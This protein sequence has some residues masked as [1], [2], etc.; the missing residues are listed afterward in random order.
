MTNNILAPIVSLLLL[1]FAGTA[2]GQIVKPEQR[3]V[4]VVK[5]KPAY[6]QK[7][8]LL[9]QLPVARAS[10]IGFTVK[11]AFPG[12]QPP[13]QRQVEGGAVDLSLVYFIEYSD[14]SDRGQLMEM[15][16]ATGDFY[17]YIEPYP[18]AV[19]VYTPNDPKIGSQEYLAQVKAYSGWDLTKG[20]KN[21]TIGVV[22]TGSDMDH[23]DLESELHL[24]Q[25]DP[26]N[27]IDDDMD[28]YVD[29][30]YGWDFYENDNDPQVTGFD[31]GA[32][33]SGIAAAAT[34]NSEGVASV[35][36]NT[37]YLPVRAGPGPSISYG[38]ESIV[39]AADMGA[40]VINCSWG[41]FSYSK[42]GEDAV[43]YAIW[44]KDALVVAASGNNNSSNKFYP[45]AYD[46]VLAVGAVD[47]F[48]V[49]AGFSNYGYWVDIMAPGVNLLSTVDNGQYNANTGT[50]AA[51][52]VVSAA[53]ALVRHQYPWMSA[54]QVAERLKTT[55][56]NIDN[57]AGNENYKNKLGYGLLNVQEALSGNVTG[58]SVVFS[59]MKYSNGENEVILAGDSLF[60]RGYFTNYL[61]ASGHLTATLSTAS[62]YV[63]FDNAV[64]D[65]GVLSPLAQIS[66]VD[67]P[68][69]MKIDPAVPANEKITFKLHIS[70]GSYTRDEYFTIE[71]NVDYRDID[72]NN[73]LMTVT[74]KS[75]LGYDG[76]GQQRGN[77]LRYLGN[78][79]SLLYESGL[80]VGTKIDG[81][82]TVS[83]NVRSTTGYDAD[84]VSKQPI[85][86]IDPPAAGHQQYRS[87]FA[88]TAASN[89]PM[90][91][92]VQQSTYAYND[93]GHRDYIVVEYRIINSDTLPLHDVYAGIFTD[94]DIGNAHKNFAY[95]D[96][97]RYLVLTES[98]NRGDPVAG[99]QL[100]SPGQF[101]TYCF[102]NVPGGNGGID[103]Y[104][105]FSD[106]E[107]YQS[108][109]WQRS[110]AGGNGGNDVI[111]AVSSGPFD[112]MPGDTHTV[113]FAILAAID[114][115]ALLNAADSA[116]LRYNGLLPLSATGNRPAGS[117]YTGPYPNPV[118]EGAWL[119]LSRNDREPVRMVVYDASGR[120]LTE[121]QWQGSVK[122]PTSGW[123]SGLYTLQLIRQAQVEWR[124]VLLIK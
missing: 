123:P 8:V 109:T 15:I 78:E 68:F 33:V 58:P 6:R 101:G 97:Q 4:I 28:G 122:I 89:I 121:L 22:D 48:N 90:G 64:F 99:V 16:A 34:D 82:I 93:P 85:Q 105:G 112:L 30:Y 31:H 108:L 2:T 10:G 88:D 46:N 77:G 27:G 70:D 24:N 32:Y 17:E 54:M 36:F 75:L 80:M 69:S 98:G 9:E 50:S 3:R 43:N 113:A 62:P 18:V 53:A 5:L 92:S 7:A 74:S 60:I 100:L 45:A 66:N 40:D 19:A 57:V 73:L 117:E 38:Y 115:P 59:A 55:A 37:S 41:S 56:M 29:N 63:Q 124:K 106:T 42:F 81:F 95:T 94:F 67:T 1:W 11:K 13:A 39:Y 26:V 12:K 44:N 107:K 61:A 103:I 35:G 104:N 72:V 47:K 111:Q 71:V 119:S 120:K 84:F 76:F 118:K 51:A 52:P 114:R 83:D 23:P 21:I 49:R 79:A 14:P 65:I 116:Y 87:F 102:D 86:S 25:D 20:S 110:G 96:W 91:I